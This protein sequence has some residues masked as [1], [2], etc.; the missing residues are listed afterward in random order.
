LTLL[1]EPVS[2]VTM[3]SLELMLEWIAPSAAGVTFGGEVVFGGGE[4]LLSLLEEALGVIS[5]LDG[6]H[7]ATRLFIRGRDPIS[8]TPLARISRTTGSPMSA[9]NRGR[10]QAGA[11][12][13]RPATGWSAASASTSMSGAWATC[14]DRRGSAC[15]WPSG[16]LTP[17][18]SLRAQVA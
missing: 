10:Y 7:H 18:S 5:L 1:V 16:P 6:G 9:A 8:A 4:V 17:P 13:L 3:A 2:T 14:A 15:P 12:E 11:L